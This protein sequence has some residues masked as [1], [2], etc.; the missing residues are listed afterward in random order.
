MKS[1]I[2][3]LTELS[4]V[5]RKGFLRAAHK[6]GREK[7]RFRI[8]WIL[9]TGTKIKF[10]F[11]FTCLI[12]IKVIFNRYLLFKKQMIKLLSVVVMTNKIK[13]LSFESY[14]KLYKLLFFKKLR[15]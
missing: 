12:V 1:C 10:F 8:Q 11:C 5:T 3:I 9:G 2:Y 4:D 15:I 13:F 14:I 6:R 7:I